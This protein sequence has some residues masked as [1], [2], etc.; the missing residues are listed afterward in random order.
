M[1][2]L[3]IIQ[4]VIPD[5][6]KELFRAIETALNNSFELYGGDFYFE[7]SVKSDLKIAKTPVINHFFFNRRLLFQ[8][9]IW[10]LLF[11]DIVLV[12]EMNP[13]ILSNWIFLVIRRTISRKTVLWGHAWPRNGVH[14]KSEILRNLMRLLANKIIVYTNQQ[15]LELKSKMQKKEILAAP[16]AVVSASMMAFSQSSN[17]FNLIYVGRLTKRKKPYFLVKAFAHEIHK[18]P[19]ETKLIIIGQGEEEGKIKKYIANNKLSNRI[20][21]FGHISDQKKLKELYFSS[22]FSVSPGYV[23]LSITQSFSF[24]VP[25]LVSK[26]ENHSPEIE[27]VIPNINALFFETDNV[28]DFNKIIMNAFDNKEYWIKQRPSIVNFCKDSYSI[29]AMSKVF[30]NLV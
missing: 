7:S 14:S 11:K 25:M 4:T 8:T 20:E 13:R 2:K 21:L 16:N 17:Q 24:G 18:L 12:M 29:E 30:I 6:R 23:G 9:G 10:H 1:R 26:D 22:F 3:V 28:N 5:Y 19:V 27:A 15:Q